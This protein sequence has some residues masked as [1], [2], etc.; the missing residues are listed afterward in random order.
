MRLAK[1]GGRY[2]ISWF[3]WEF[4]DRQ[5]VA[6]WSCR[7]DRGIGFGDNTEY[8]M[9]GIFVDRMFD[10]LGVWLIKGVLIHTIT[11]G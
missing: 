8:W 11:Y 7:D 2:G 1:L 4:G 6:E 3:L 9:G 10:L 5:F